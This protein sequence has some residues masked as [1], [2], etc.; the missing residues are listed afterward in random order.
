MED[1]RE[2]SPLLLALSGTFVVLV[3]LDLVSD[4]LEGG[5][6]AHL[7]LEAILLAISGLVF[8]RGIQQLRQARQKIQSLKNDVEQLSEEKEKWQGETHQLLAG[9]SVKIE[10]QFN[11]ST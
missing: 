5:T 4:Y 3:G 10:N 11:S 7:T 9:L 8:G 1:D 2:T 6:G